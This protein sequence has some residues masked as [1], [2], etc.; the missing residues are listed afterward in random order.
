MWQTKVWIKADCLHFW[1][2]ITS[3]YSSSYFFQVK[4]GP[5]FFLASDRAVRIWY[6][7][8]SSLNQVVTM[9]I[10]IK[11]L[12]EH[13]SFSRRKKKKKKIV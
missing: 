6:F 2:Q 12:M 5:F 7:P 10:N 4:L 3:K 9:M 1:K 8:I 13:F 11:Q